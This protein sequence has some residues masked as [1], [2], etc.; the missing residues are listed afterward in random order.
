VFKDIVARAIDMVL[1]GTLY[2]LLGVVIACLV[3]TT[4]CLGVIMRV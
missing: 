4:L 1:A 2:V 3:L